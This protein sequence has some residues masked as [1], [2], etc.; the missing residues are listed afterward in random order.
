VLI[1]DAAIATDQSAKFVYLVGSD[2]KLERRPVTTG[3]VSKELRVITDGLDG[4]E[5]V[6]IKGLQ[7][8]RPGVEAKTTVEEIVAGDDLG[9]PD[10]YEPVA[11]EEWLRPAMSPIN[12]TSNA[13][14]APPMQGAI[15]Q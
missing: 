10:T 14:T 3:S 4:S 15:A 9:L 12:A 6:V 2:G 13:S 11:P 5:M 7:R 8:C 1:P